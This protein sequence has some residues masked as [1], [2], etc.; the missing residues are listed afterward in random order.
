MEPL[1][2]VG[3]FLVISFAPSVVMFYW[4]IQSIF[5]VHL[6]NQGVLLILAL[7]FLGLI[8]FLV[9]VMHAEITYF[10]IQDGTLCLE[11]IRNKV[12]C[13]LSYDYLVDPFEFW[14]TLAFKYF[15]ALGS[16]IFTI[17]SLDVILNNTLR[18]P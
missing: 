18:K 16:I 14:T 6:K 4:I 10:A 15:I 7:A 3:Y 9:F 2:A 8:S 17:F 13:R 1:S 11:E 5:T 12:D